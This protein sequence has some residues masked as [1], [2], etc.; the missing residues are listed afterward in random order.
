M[1]TPAIYRIA[2]VAPVFPCEITADSWKSWF[3]AKTKF[4]LTH[5]IHRDATHWRPLTA[6]EPSEP[7]GERRKVDPPPGYSAE[8][9][10]RDNPYNAWMEEDAPAPAATG[11]PTP[12]TDTAKIPR[13]ELEQYPNDTHFLR[14][15]FGES[16]ETELAEAKAALVEAKGRADGYALLLKEVRAQLQ[17]A[18]KD[19]E[20]LDWLEK[21][22]KT[23][24]YL[25]V[26]G[27][28]KIRTTD[29]LDGRVTPPTY[30]NLRSAINA[31]R[32]PQPPT[33]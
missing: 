1:T 8:E 10:D 30:I 20:R 16:L 33:T 3:I 9:L 5:G 27:Q 29:E 26:D 13:S 6:P 17:A 32:N 31:A 25:H 21:Q 7:G 12:R 14:C 24:I 23:W 15:S 4:T 18:Q 2:E 22:R 11:T 19:G 28:V